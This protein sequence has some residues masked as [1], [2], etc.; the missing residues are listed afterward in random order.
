[1]GADA[2][3]CLL[4][5][6]MF[7]WHHPTALPLYSRVTADNF[8]DEIRKEHENDITMYKDTMKR[9]NGILLTL[10]VTG[11]ALISGS[12]YLMFNAQ[13]RAVGPSLL[14][15]GM[16]CIWSIYREPFLLMNLKV[17]IV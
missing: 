16:G 15:L 13:Y 3:V 6:K 2:H 12:V 14:M 4:T 9:V 17:R 8:R 1:M 10:L 11:I 7:S 5:D